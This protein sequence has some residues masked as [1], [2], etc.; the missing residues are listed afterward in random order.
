[1]GA[2]GPGQSGTPKIDVKIQKEGLLCISE[3]QA[4]TERNFSTGG[5]VVGRARPRS[6]EP[7]FPL[8]VPTTTRGSRALSLSASG[9]CSQSLLLVT[10]IPT[11]A[12]GGRLGEQKAANLLASTLVVRLPRKSWFWKNRQTCGGQGFSSELAP[13]NP[14]SRIPSLKGKQ[15]VASLPG[16]P[17]KTQVPWGPGSLALNAQRASLA[18]QSSGSCQRQG[19]SQPG[20]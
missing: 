13:P 11:V 19:G 3:P 15:Q 7:V 20:L 17:V 2:P 16:H 8:E 6:S 12:R 10:S 1:M 9:H 5:H 4:V 18:S 14:S